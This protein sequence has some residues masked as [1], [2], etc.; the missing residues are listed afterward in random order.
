MNDKKRFR[1]TS[2]G[3][4]LSLLLIALS[5]TKGKSK[6]DFYFNQ[7]EAFHTFYDIKY[8]SNRPLDEPIDKA[9]HELNNVANPFEE[10]TLLYK[11]NHNQ[12]HQI[13]SIFRVLFESALKVSEATGGMYDITVGPFVNAW[14]FGFEPSAWPDGN[15]PEEA[16]DSIRQFVGYTKVRIQGNTLYKADPRIRLDMASIAKGYASDLVAKALSDNASENYLVEIGGEIAFAGLNPERVPWRVGVSKPIFD[17]LG[18]ASDE[19]ACVLH[20]TGKGG[21][22]TSGNYHNYKVRPDG[23]RYAHTI[24]PLSGRPIESDVL[25]ATI[26]APNCAIADAL[27]TASMTLGSERALQLCEAWNEVE[28]LL[29][30]TDSTSQEGYRMIQSSGMKR[31]L[32]ENTTNG[33]E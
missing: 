11:I 22:A 27:A 4:A 33:K 12:P 31:F 25:S 8:S 2:V 32:E 5:C 13:D 18:L 26:I 9:L 17:T 16:L 7:G 1:F 19:L 20:L 21:M 6:V 10:G 29:L 30:V 24:D 15:V 28:C 23:S 14:G 3:I